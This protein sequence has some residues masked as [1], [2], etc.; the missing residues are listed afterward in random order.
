MAGAAEVE[1]LERGSGARETVLK[2]R[3]LLFCRMVIF[4]EFSVFYICVGNRSRV[5]ISWAFRVG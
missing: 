1:F 2:V 3:L 5:I 4:R